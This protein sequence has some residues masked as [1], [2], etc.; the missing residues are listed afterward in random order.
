MKAIRNF[1][2]LDEYKMYSLSSQVFEGITEY[3]VDY[4]SQTKEEQE[5]QKGPIGSGRIMADIIRQG[6]ET[7]EKRFLHD[8][9]YHLFEEHLREQKKVLN[10]DGGS[11]ANFED[12]LPDYSFVRIKSTA[13]FNDITSIKDTINNFNKIG[14]AL[15]HVTNFKAIEEVKQ[16]LELAQSTIK[17][18]NEKAA[19]QERLKSLTNL[20]KFAK[21]KG[22][23]Q[24]QK[25][26]DNLSLIIWISGSI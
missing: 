19:L 2:Y 7:Q 23:H 24:D 5:T 12:A 26:L 20:A 15:A 13:T 4:K 3:L 16:Q 11:L 25:L 1:I 18:R 21:E 8:Y 14:E 9:S 17:D 6:S 22:L 10:I